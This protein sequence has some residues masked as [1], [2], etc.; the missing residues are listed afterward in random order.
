MKRKLVGSTVY[1]VP[2]ILTGLLLAC[3]IN[4]SNAEHPVLSATLSSATNGSVYYVA[5][6][7]PGA[8]D[9]N[10]GLYPT[11]QGGHWITLW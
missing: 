4:P 3:C 10:N 8:S 6:N 5:V 9:S 11:Y 2:A 7:E 1:W